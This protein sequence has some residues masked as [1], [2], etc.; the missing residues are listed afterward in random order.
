MNESAYKSCGELPLFLNA[1]PVAQA[2]EEN[3]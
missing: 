1:K 2:H 3:P